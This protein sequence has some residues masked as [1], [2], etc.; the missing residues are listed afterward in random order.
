MDLAPECL[1][2]ARSKEPTSGPVCGDVEALPFGDATFGCT[3]VTS[4]LQWLDDPGVA[5]S[6]LGRVTAPNGTLLLV[7]WLHGSFR[8]LSELRA[9]FGV[10]DPVRLLSEEAVLKAVLQAGF[11]VTAQ[12]R[13]SGQA[14]YPTALAAIKSLVGTGSSAHDASSRSP[15]VFD[16]TREYAKRFGDEHGVP[17][18]HET[19]VAV[20][21][22]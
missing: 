19:L 9:E 7:A 21:R 11:E 5:L 22:K 20:A 4:V 8:E 6:E 3:A 15:Q 10:P 18:S 14:T 13:I 17:V 1:R 12:E 2:V 16:L